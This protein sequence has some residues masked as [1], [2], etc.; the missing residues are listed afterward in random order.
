MNDKIFTF[1][2]QLTAHK[3]VWHLKHNKIVFLV[4]K[5]SENGKY[6]IVSYRLKIRNGREWLAVWGAYHIQQN[7][8][9]I[10][11]LV[12]NQASDYEEWTELLNNGI[13]KTE[14]MGIDCTLT[15]YFE[16]I[17]NGDDYVFPKNAGFDAYSSDRVDEFGKGIEKVF[18]EY[19]F[20]QRKNIIYNKNKPESNNCFRA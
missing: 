9:T 3:I 8:S 11:V 5:N 14:F 16:D 10:S 20:S 2:K 4:C 1:L 19:W 18:A 12:N 17:F 13:G 15:G 6:M 7:T